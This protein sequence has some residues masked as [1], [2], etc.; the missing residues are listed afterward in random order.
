MSLVRALSPNLKEG[1]DRKT[2][3]TLKKRFLEINDGR[4]ERTMNALSDRHR[5]FLQ[6]LP[7]LIHVNHPILPGYISGKT[8]CGISQFEANKEQIRAAQ[9]VDKGF[10]YKRDAN[11]TPSIYSVALMGSAGTVAYSA[12]SDMDFWVVHRPGLN[13]KALDELRKKLDAIQKWTESMGMEV[14]FFMIDPDKFRRGERGDQLDAEDCGSTQHYLL[15][16][17]FYRTSLLIA[18]RY[19][20]WWLVPT[21]QEGDY[22]EISN[23]L[24]NKRFIEK[25]EVFDI[26]GI[27]DFPAGEFLGAGLWQLYKGID[28]PYKSVLK[29]LLTEV[30]ASEYP[31]VNPLSL[32]YKKAIYDGK[33]D[34]DELDP[35]VLVYRKIEQYLQ[36]KKESNRLELVRRCLYFK[37]NQPLTKPVAK[38]KLAWQH[39]LMSKLIKQWKWDQPKLHTLDTRAQWKVNRVIGERKAVV[40][41]LN[42]SYRFLSRFARENHS[43]AH[44]NHRDMT[45]LGRK[46]YAAFERKS[47]KVELV[48]PGIA[49]NISEAHLSFYYDQPED[50]SQKPSWVMYR[51]YIQPRDKVKEDPIKRSRSIIELIA[52]AYFNKLITESTRYYLEATGSDM[53]EHE[54]QRIVQSF[55]QLFPERLKPPEQEHFE[56]LAISSHA[57][58]YINVGRDPMASMS[59]KGIQRLSNHTDALK[60]SGLHNNLV[61]QIDQLFVNSWNEVTVNQFSE[62]TS[63]IDCLVDL[64]RN[65]P[66]KK[67]KRLPKLDI[68]C[69]CPSRP[70]AIAKRVKELFYDV[71]KAFYTNPMGMN[72]RYIL[73][74]ESHFFMLHFDGNQPRA[75]AL[76]N[77]GSL[78]RYLSNPIDHYSPILLDRY[79]L[80]GSVLSVLAANGLPHSIQ[81]FYMKKEEQ[82]EVYVLDEKSTLYS[83]TTENFKDSAFMN[84]MRRFLTSALQRQEVELAQFEEDQDQIDINFYEIIPAQNN[85]AINAVERFSNQNQ[86]ND[87]YFQVQVIFNEDMN[88]K[89]LHTIY[90]DHQEFSELE[91]GKKLFSAVAEHIQSIR[92]SDT[93]YPVYITDIDL[94]RTQLKLNSERP[95]QISEYLQHK[96]KLEKLLNKALYQPP[97]E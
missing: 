16:D 86:G 31:T 59:K 34:L 23:T 82:A 85:Q 3:K 65:H 5:I 39:E 25:D 48:N 89:P 78:M 46:L 79:A 93:N 50:E 22:E 95:M 60:Y 11:K 49:P 83:F 51:E 45:L 8:P 87:S 18:G 73:E 47:G 67:V 26:G 37:V 57:A 12:K 56:K 74:F 97:S 64:L 4:L 88:G 75:K 58:I 15:L 14:Y 27:S 13:Q 52:W 68:R 91:Y 36:E 96:Q 17:E 63:I 28:S 66:P 35:Y 62:S 43:K 10:E 90:C 94:T 33:L 6:A 38:K 41:E 54:L 19:P 72:T 69:Y 40:N 80:E 29:I 71:I 42:L 61:L 55:F 76:K 2:L 24:V 32:I 21:D 53:T 7:I 20:V 30:Y 1:I 84:Q 70:I 9:T 92:E 77:Y 44:V 81:I